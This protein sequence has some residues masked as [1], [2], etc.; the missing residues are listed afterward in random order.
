MVDFG[1][2]SHADLL[3]APLADLAQAVRARTLD[4]ADARTLDHVYRHRLLRSILRRAPEEELLALAVHLRVVVLPSARPALD[5][6]GAPWSRIWDAY[7]ELLE[8]RV[9]VMR[10]Q[11]PEA[12]LGRAHVMGVLARVRAG[13]DSG[14]AQQDLLDPPRLKKANLTRV[15]HLMEANELIERRLVGRE[16]QVFLGEAGRRLAGAAPSAAAPAEEVAERP[17]RLLTL[18]RAG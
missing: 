6:L 3:A 4:E 18:R 8:S 17:G 12:V 5:T 14:V 16:N 13:G 2:D 7:A 10:A 11:D 15:L 1:R 9:A